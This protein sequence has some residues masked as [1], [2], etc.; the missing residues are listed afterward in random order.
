MSI[1]I[2]ICLMIFAVLTLL[3]VFVLKSPKLNYLFVVQVIACFALI[4]LTVSVVGIRP[5][6][7]ALKN[8]E[9]KTTE[10]KSFKYIDELHNSLKCCIIN[11]PDKEWPENVHF[12]NSCCDSSQLR[13]VG[14]GEKE[15]NYRCPAKKAYEDCFHRFLDKQQGFRRTAVVC[16]TLALIFSLSFSFYNRER[17]W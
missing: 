16:L 10:E 12:L 17:D 15:S 8:V 1:A 14:D 9:K 2:G 13:P 4:I 11:V 5:F 6:E 7:D 3:A